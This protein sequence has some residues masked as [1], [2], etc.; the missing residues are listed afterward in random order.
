MFEFT[1]ALQSALG[2]SLLYSS[3][4]S[5]AGGLAASLTP[6]VYPL[7]PVIA[8]YVG[9]SS[10]GSSTRKTAF[11]LSLAYVL[12][13]AVVYSGLGI[14]AALTG[15]LFGSI[16]ANPWVQIAV[17]NVFILLG[18][19]MMDAIP[20]PFL[21]GRSAGDSGKKGIT[22]AFLL[23]AASG[24]VA[25]PCTAPVLGVVLTY[26]ATTQNVLWG[27]VLLFSFSLGFGMLLLA[28]GT[29]SGVAAALP[30][31]GNWMVYLKKSLGLAM[32]VLAQ[33]YLI[34]AGQL[35]F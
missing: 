2:T 14:A 32:I 11:L 23:G 18:L 3:G 12:G 8:S 13:L 31:P 29:F 33:Y 24:L 30:K 10:L 9:S 16:G 1:S 27:F 17:A 26:V 7:L 25:S 28:V 15:M 35:M 6:C 20:L 34:S 22:G 21:S 4:I 5:F 19:N